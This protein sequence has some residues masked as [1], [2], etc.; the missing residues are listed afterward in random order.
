MYPSCSEY[1]L[2]AISKHG[3]LIGW[4]MTID[5]LMR[6][7]RDEIYLSPEIMVNGQWKIY[8]TVEQNDFWWASANTDNAFKRQIKQSREWEISIE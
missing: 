8:D 4:I 2:S 1:A 5:R 7:G 3:A 6:C